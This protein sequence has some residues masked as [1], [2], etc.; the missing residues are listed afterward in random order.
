MALEKE[1]EEQLEKYLSDAF[2][3]GSEE[4][5]YEVRRVR[6][7]QRDDTEEIIKLMKDLKPKE[8]ANASRDISILKRAHA[9]L[10]FELII[11]LRIE[12]MYVS[13]L[14]QIRL[15]A[16]DGLSLE[17]IKLSLLQSIKITKF[18]KYQTLRER[19][20]NEMINDYEKWLRKILKE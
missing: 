6:E 18:P 10:D 16:E 8:G 2:Y 15:G 11:G 1:E 4:Q 12:D 13:F 19:I 14:S 5:V 9:P 7:L 3:F 17:E 20:R